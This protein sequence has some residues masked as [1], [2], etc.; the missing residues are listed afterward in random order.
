[1]RRT[2]EDI[3]EVARWRDPGGED[4]P[5][6]G[7]GCGRSPSYLCRRA[8]GGTLRRDG[9]RLAETHPDMHL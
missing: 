8:D 5:S 1:V 6:A 9:R 7:A 3:R 4:R 2:D